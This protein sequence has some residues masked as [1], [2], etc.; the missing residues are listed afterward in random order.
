MTTLMTTLYDLPA[1][2]IFFIGFM[3]WISIY[4][5][6][7]VHDLRKRVGALEPKQDNPDQATALVLLRSEQMTARD[8]MDHC[9]ANGWDP[10]FGLGRDR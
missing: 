7:A 2:Q 10:K 9:H 3:F 6:L 1:V 4:V 8:Y 5:M